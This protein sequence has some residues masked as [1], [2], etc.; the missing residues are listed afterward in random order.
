M[1]TE[2]R[3]HSC[4]DF[5]ASSH[6]SLVSSSMRRSVGRSEPAL[7]S[8]C[9]VG[10]DVPK[11]DPVDG[12]GDMGEIELLVWSRL[13]KSRVR[14]DCGWEDLG[15]GDGNLASEGPFDRGRLSAA[16]VS[17]FSPALS[18]RTCTVTL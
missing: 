2:T 5:S 3:S 12:Y 10:C 8:T 6:S 4:A 13:D 15:E 9:C 17:L 16:S 18:S 11:G 14:S 1:A 7:A